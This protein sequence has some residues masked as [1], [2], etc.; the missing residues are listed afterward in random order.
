MFFY[1]SEKELAEI[2]ELENEKEREEESESKE[3]EHETK[4]DIRKEIDSGEEYRED[5]LNAID[6]MIRLNDGEY[7]ILF[8]CSL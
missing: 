3:S 8:Y 6:E 4:E 7:C 2:D 5:E 1:V